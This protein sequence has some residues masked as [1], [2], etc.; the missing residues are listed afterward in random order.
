MQTR[1]TFLG[2]AGTVTGSR[3]LLETRGKKLLIDC[4]LFQGPKEHRLKN[5]EPFGFDAAEI[6]RVMLTHAHIDHT[7]LLPKLV[8]EGFSGPVT[9]TTATCDLAKIMLPDTGHLQEEEAKWANKRGYSKH[10]P[11]LPLF[12][13]QDAEAVLPLLAPVAYGE[14]F[15]PAENVRGQFRDAGHILGSA[16]LDLKAKRLQGTRKIVFGGDLGR[17]ADAI[18]RCPSQAYNIDYLVLESTYGNR[19]HGEQDPVRELARVVNA[20]LE[21]G[22]VLVI[23][24]FAVGRAQTLL[25]VLRELESAGAIPKVPIYVDSPMAIEAL[26][27]HRAHVPDLNLHCRAQAIAGVGL[28]RPEKLKLSVTRDDS[29][30]INSIDSG[31]IIISASGMCTGGRILHHL[32]ERLPDDRNTILFIGYQGV[33]TRGRTI[34]EGKPVV[35]MFGGEV[36]VKA[37]IENISGFSGHAD[38]NEILAWLMGCN[39]PPERVF[40]VHGEAE[41]AREMAERVRSQFKW[42]VTIPAEGDSFLLDF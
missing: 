34:V 7:G 32:A 4:G 22:G 31:A 40:I 35:R 10:R 28:F 36:P 41:A 1:L 14:H 18:L 11:A 27:V 19:L 8:K 39:R 6:D 37:K 15:A 30:R 12:T 2:A 5:R 21:R 17:P 33:G 3:Y 25:Y 23:P 13:K 20:S 26:E 38:Y 9:A 16:H 24:S 29:I 42:D